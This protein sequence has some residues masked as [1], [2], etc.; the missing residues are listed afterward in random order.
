MFIEENIKLSNA[1]RLSAEKYGVDPVYLLD[2]ADKILISHAILEVVEDGQMEIAGLGE[3][4]DPMFKS[5]P[6]GLD[7]AKRLVDEN[8]K[9]REFMDQ[10]NE[11]SE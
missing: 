11:Q 5:T 4:G 3:D 1:I 2:W 9:A 6:E 10:L 8:P 7:Y